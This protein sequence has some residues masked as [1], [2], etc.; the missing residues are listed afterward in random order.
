M[1]ARMR[2]YFEE[3]AQDRDLRVVL[4]RGAGGTFIS[5][6]DIKEFLEQRTTEEVLEG[7]RLEEEM[8]RAI[9]RIPAPVVAVIEGYG[10]GGGLTLAAACDLRICTTDA[11]LGIPSA[12]S[13]GNSL[14]AGMYARLASIIGQAR[15]RELL[16]LAPTLS[17]ETALAWG[18]VNEVV[19]P[20][21]LEQ[22]L[23][24]LVA[25]LSTHAPLTMWAAKEAMVRQIQ[26]HPDTSDVSEKVL[27]S[28]D[29]REGIDAFVE[30]REPV[31]RNE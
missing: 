4:L 15:V 29:F 9:E 16:I 30:K 31:W 26:P 13:L 17:A 22:R 18:L 8:S 14:A 7:A 12:K 27:G 10:L 5:G 11:K 21:A 20:D 24:E 23:S 19:A 6:A 1:R 3:L 28:R 25:Q 2:E